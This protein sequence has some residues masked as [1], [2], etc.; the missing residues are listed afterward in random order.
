MATI[1]ILGDLSMVELI[2][3]LPIDKRY[4]GYELQPMVVNVPPKVQAIHGIDLN[5]EGCDQYGNTDKGGIYFKIVTYPI[6]LSKAYPFDTDIFH[7]VL[8][9]IRFQSTALS[10]MFFNIGLI[11]NSLRK[12]KTS[13][14]AQLAKMQMD[15]DRL[16]NENFSLLKGFKEASKSVTEK[17]YLDDDEPED[18]DD[19]K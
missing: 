19:K 16:R 10:D 7:Y 8:T 3:F 11:N 5:D 2:R 13:I 17:T 18:D 1:I 4:A 6:Y 15:N 9:G 14:Q 12:E